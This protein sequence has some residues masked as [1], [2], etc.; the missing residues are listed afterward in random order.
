MLVRVFLD[1]HQDKPVVVAT[2]YS[3]ILSFLKWGA[4]CVST[5]V[6][7]V[8]KAS[9]TREQTEIRIVPV[10]LHIVYVFKLIDAL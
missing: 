2:I 1:V 7:L 9:S 5:L 4:A 10:L 6:I 3:I 8:V